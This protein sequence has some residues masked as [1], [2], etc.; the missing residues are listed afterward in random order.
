[1]LKASD[2]NWVCSWPTPDAERGELAELRHGERRDSPDRLVIR[3][4]AAEKALALRRREIVLD[5]EAITSALITDDPW[6][7]LRG[8]HSRNEASRSLALGTWRASGRDFVIAR[9]KRP[10]VVIDFDTA[11]V[12]PAMP[13]AVLDP[14]PPNTSPSTSSNG[15]CCRRCTRRI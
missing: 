13:S 5:R 8:V 2:N 12:K 15:W 14:D 1:M 10:A 4:G 6:M 11:A 9:S 7:W 3:L